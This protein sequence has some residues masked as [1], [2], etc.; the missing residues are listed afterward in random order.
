MLHTSAVN[1]E[2]EGHVGDAASHLRVVRLLALIDS[3]EQ[4]HGD[5]DDQWKEHRG[6]E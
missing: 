5:G 2:Q 1:R 6:F 4:P 3:D